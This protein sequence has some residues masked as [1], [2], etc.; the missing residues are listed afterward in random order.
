MEQVG[1]A[2]SGLVFGKSGT[3]EER[4]ESMKTLCRRLAEHFAKLEEITLKIYKAHRNLEESLQYATKDYA[5]LASC[6]KDESLQ[7]Q[8]ARLSLASEDQSQLYHDFAVS[9]KTEFITSVHEWHKY[10][11]AAKD[12]LKARDEKQGN[13]ADLNAYLS[14]SRQQHN[15]LR[16]MST[17]QDE[18]D[19]SLLGPIKQ[20]AKAVSSYVNSHIDKMKGLD[21]ITAKQQKIV[22]LEK[23]IGDLEA[24]LKAAEGQS[25]TADEV[26]EREMAHFEDVLRNELQDDLL[27]TIQRLYHQLMTKS[28]SHWEHL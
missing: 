18:A 6:V 22:T 23:R 10:S 19:P 12:S 9:L 11:C 3:I 8:L 5:I 27:P 7:K 16:G 2:V 26:V 13:C 24:A 21:M 17:G 15:E 28:V 4:F 25:A 20:G 1:D 14:K